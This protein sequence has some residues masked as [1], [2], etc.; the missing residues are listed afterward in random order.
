MQYTSDICVCAC[1]LYAGWGGL[2]NKSPYIKVFLGR[3]A[4][5]CFIIKI[6]GMKDRRLGSENPN[7]DGFQQSIFKDEGAQGPDM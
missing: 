7:S 2:A 1:N 4:G 5:E 3:R 6:H